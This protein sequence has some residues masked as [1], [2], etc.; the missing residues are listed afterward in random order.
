MA[1]VHLFHLMC[2]QMLVSVI[3]SFKCFFF[4]F[5]SDLKLYKYGAALSDC[6]QVLKAEPLNVKA[7]LRRGV[8]QQNKNNYEQV[9]II[10]LACLEWVT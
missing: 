3:I 1:D 4:F 6:S 8:A 10:L 5:N 7:L 2:H 9:H